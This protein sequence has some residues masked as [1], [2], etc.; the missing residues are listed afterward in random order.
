MHTPTAP[1][2]SGNGAVPRHMQRRMQQFCSLCAPQNLALH[3]PPYALVCVE[4]SMLSKEVGE[5]VTSQVHRSNPPHLQQR[6][7]QT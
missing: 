6:S 4:R 1:E 2:Q 7:L 3:V 5:S